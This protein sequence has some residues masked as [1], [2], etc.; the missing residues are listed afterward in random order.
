[1]LDPARALLT[2]QP[3]L[4]PPPPLSPE[5]TEG[6]GCSWLVMAGFMATRGLLLWVSSQDREE[7]KPL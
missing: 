7:L 3:T 4:L 6:S 5:L 2:L 1:M